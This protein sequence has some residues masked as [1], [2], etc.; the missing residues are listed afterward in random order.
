[1]R[2]AKATAKARLAQE[3]PATKKLARGSKI[4]N[5]R[6]QKYLRTIHGVK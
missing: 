5:E 1:M 2:C 4:R 6:N 3:T